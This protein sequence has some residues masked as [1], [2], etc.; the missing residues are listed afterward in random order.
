MYVLPVAVAPFSY[1][2]IMT[3]PKKTKVH[4]VSSGFVDDVMFPYNGEN[5]PES[6][7]TRKFRP[8]CYMAVPGA[9][10]AVFN[11][12]LLSIKKNRDLNNFCFLNDFVPIIFKFAANKSV[13]LYYFTPAR[14]QKHLQILY[15]TV[16]E[17]EA[18][19]YLRSAYDCA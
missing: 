19:L 8:L 5:K 14:R 4:N 2:G 7:T 13:I 3:S 10:S 1:D 16:A 15:E 6:K 12:I 11:C 9:K 18:L 17:Y